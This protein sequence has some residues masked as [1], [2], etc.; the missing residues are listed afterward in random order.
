MFVRFLFVF[1]LLF[2]LFRIALWPSVGKE[3]S[4]WLFTCAVFYFSAV[5]IVGV[6]YPFGVRHSD[7]FYGRK[8]PQEVNHSLTHNASLTLRMCA[9]GRRQL[10]CLWL[11]GAPPIGFRQSCNA[12]ISW[13]AKAINEPKSS[14]VTVDIPI[15][16]LV[17]GL[18]CPLTVSASVVL[19]S[20]YLID[21]ISKY[22]N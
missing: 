14:E 4:P 1:D 19:P 7:E 3:L 10:S 8:R 20:S 18:F 16:H 11:F 13:L 15:V 12:N 9:H 6:P 2:N 17:T 5:L 21:L 22:K